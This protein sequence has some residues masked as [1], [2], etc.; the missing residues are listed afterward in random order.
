MAF[1]KAIDKATVPGFNKKGQTF[2]EDTRD[3][4][5]RNRDFMTKEVNEMKLPI[6]AVNVEGG[7]FLMVDITECHDMIPARYTTQ[8][9]YEDPGDKKPVN[10]YHLFKRDGTIPKDL[11]F[12]RWMAHEHGIAMMPISF[13]YTPDSPNM[14]DNYARMAICKNYDDTVKCINRLKALRI[15]RPRAKL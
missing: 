10:K 5:I 13:F 1:S 2:L 7:Y 8:H 9:E 3:Y 4:F 15:E 6:K 14:T 11:A 12:C